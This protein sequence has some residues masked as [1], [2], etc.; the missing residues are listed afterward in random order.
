LNNEVFSLILIGIN[1]AAQEGRY[2]F[3]NGLKNLNSI[4]DNGA[5]YAAGKGH[6]HILQWLATNNIYPTTVGCD[7]AARNGHILI[8]RMV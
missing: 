5:K 8:F 2:I 3:Y 4:L 1:I 7:Y 6:L